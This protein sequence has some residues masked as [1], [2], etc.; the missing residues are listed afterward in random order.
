MCRFALYLGARIPLASLVTDP[1]HSIVRQSHHSRERAEPLNGDGFG[2]AWYT[3]EFSPQPA[4]FRDL[5]PAWNNQNLINIA[6]VT[7]SHCILAHVRAA[8]AGPVAQL[9]CHPFAADRFTFMHN[10]DVAGFGSIRRR[11]LEGLSDEAFHAISRSTDSEHVFALFLDQHR[12][13]GGHAGVEIMADALEATIAEISSLAT[14]AG[15]NDDSYLNLA[16]SDGL[17][18]VVSRHSTGAPEEANSLYLHDGGNYVCEQ[19]VCR[20]APEGNGHGAVLIASE[21]LT[22]ESSWRQVPTN[23]LVMV[24]PQRRLTIRAIAACASPNPVA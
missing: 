8:S 1:A 4:V 3:P 17:S 11:L 2:V 18:A 23:H 5:T 19:G 6:R 12:R 24:D 21:P 7:T 15:S 20:M 9:N 13:L 22:A 14:A 16:V 10:G